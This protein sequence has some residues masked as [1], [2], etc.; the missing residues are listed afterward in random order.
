MRIAFPTQ[1]SSVTE[2]K[3]SKVAVS[4][5][6]RGPKA[7]AA[8]SSPA[9]VE[10]E[11]TGIGYESEGAS[12]PS[13]Y[14]SRIS[15]DVDGVQVGTRRDSG[16]NQILVRNKCSPSQ[17]AMMTQSDAEAAPLKQARFHNHAAQAS[18]PFK[19]ARFEEESCRKG[20]G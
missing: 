12:P 20:L 19:A 18:R 11:H 6:E 15:V 13:P 14:L 16:C 3:R 8:C 5:C 9:S 1:S 10:V 2:R 17:A 4:E 7:A